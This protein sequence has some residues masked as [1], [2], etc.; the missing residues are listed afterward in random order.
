MAHGSVRTMSRWTPQL[1]NRNNIFTQTK[2]TRA[3]R[4]CSYV[5]VPCIIVLYYKQE[6]LWWGRRYIYIYLSIKVKFWLDVKT[7]IITKIQGSNIEQLKGFNT[8]CDQRYN[9]I[10]TETDRWLHTHTH[11]RNKLI[12]PQTKITKMGGRES[13]LTAWLLSRAD[14]QITLLARLTSLTL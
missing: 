4:K 8:E 1:F 9:K 13:C 14:N 12:H 10:Y 11:A 3:Q 5:I 7:S 6:L 2:H